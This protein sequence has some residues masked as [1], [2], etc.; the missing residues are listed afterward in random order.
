MLPGLVV[1]IRTGAALSE[2]AADG[3]AKLGKIWG[4]TSPETG[5]RPSL[6]EGLLRFKDLSIILAAAGVVSGQERSIAHL[7]CYAAASGR[8]GGFR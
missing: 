5:A 7:T 8:R 4:L 2:A 3:P 6:A 1:E